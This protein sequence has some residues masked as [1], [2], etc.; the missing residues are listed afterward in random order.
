MAEAYVGEVRLFAATFVPAGWLPCLGQELQISQY[1]ALF[2]LIGTYFG[3]DGRNTFK[4]PDLRGRVPMQVGQSDFGTFNLG[5]KGGGA[6]AA[7]TAVGTATITD[8]NQLPAH[9]HT[10]TINVSND[11]GGS[12]TPLQK[13][14]LGTVKSATAAAAPNLYVATA[15]ATTALN[16]GAAT[17]GPAGSLK[18]EPIGITV[19]GQATP[20]LPPALGMYYAIC[21]SGIFPPRP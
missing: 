3:G 1:S 9:T 7:V 10:A 12:A 21:W 18:P 4:L 6:P 8:V 2:A 16:D 5:T 17:I 11:N 19:T 14:Y 20:T 13:G 15:A